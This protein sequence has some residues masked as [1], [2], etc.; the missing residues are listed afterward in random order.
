MARLI[1]DLRRAFDFVIIDSAPILPVN[2][3]KFLSQLVD[4]V[5]FVT[6]WETTPREAARNAIRAFED[7]KAT[8]AGVALTRADATR[9]HFYNYGYQNYYSY[10]KYYE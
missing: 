2:D 3:A 8:I 6:R 10:R 9:F 1:G 5:L 7:V 4:T